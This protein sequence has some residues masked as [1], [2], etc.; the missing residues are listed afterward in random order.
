VQ[1]TL[2]PNS[3]L[4]SVILNLLGAQETPCFFGAVSEVTF[5]A[6][7]EAR[8]H[9]EEVV[10]PGGEKAIVSVAAIGLNKCPRCWVRGNFE[11]MCHRCTLVK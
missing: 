10:L 3:A 9:R 5:D 11:H 7:D 8:Q 6:Q 4:R 1:L 2:A